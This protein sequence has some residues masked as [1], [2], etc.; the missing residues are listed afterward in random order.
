[1]T[2]T[3]LRKTN[4]L[5]YDW[6]INSAFLPPLWIWTW[7]PPSVLLSR[8][9]L[10]HPNEYP[11]LSLTRTFLPFFSS[12]ISTSALSL[13][14][15]PP[16]LLVLTS[17]MTSS[18]L[19]SHI[20]SSLVRPEYKLK[21]YTSYALPSLRFH[22]TNHDLTKTQLSSLDALSTRFLNWLSLPPCATTS[23]LYDPLS[24]NL[25]TISFVY[26]ECHTLS[27]SL[28]LSLSSLTGSFSWSSCPFRSLK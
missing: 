11:S 6:S 2:S 13:V 18:S 3:S 17:S 25:N 4:A 5:I 19:L 20:N 10:A 7:N 23:V 9:F 27:L 12:L 26:S 16:R 22:L 1:M 8:S 14:V 24:L 28:S 15:L 21:V